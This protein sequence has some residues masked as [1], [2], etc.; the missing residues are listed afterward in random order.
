MVQESLPQEILSAGTPLIS[1]TSQTNTMLPDDVCVDSLPHTSQP[2]Q[3]TPTDRGWLKS[4][5]TGSASQPL[6]F[7]GM[8][9]DWGA[10]RWS[11]RILQELLHDQVLKFRIGK[12]KGQGMQK[13]TLKQQSHVI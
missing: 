8:I 9:K 1:M 10:T 11:P 4:Y 7:T 3:H 6:V 12:R 2:P 5:I 13:D